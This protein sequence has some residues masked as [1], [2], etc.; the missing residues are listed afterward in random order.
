VTDSDTGSSFKLAFWQG[1]LHLS[2]IY[3]VARLTVP[4]AFYYSFRGIA[5]A[6]GQAPR[7]NPLQFM[8]DHLL[9]FSLLCG[10]A[11]GFGSARFFQNK[12]ILYVWTVPAMVLAFCFVFESP[13]VYPTMILDSDFGQAFHFYFGGGF[14][15]SGQ[16]HSYHE[17]IRDIVPS[18]DILRAS[19]QLSITLPAYVG[20]AYSIEAWLSIRL[21]ERFLRSEI[22]TQQRETS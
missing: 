2:V 22:P 3:V 5:I 13:G 16:W 10:I 17:M 4:A 15:F 9:G 18:R 11:V 7:V 1:V 14:H 20:V 19:A 6:S 8:L 21:R 12:V